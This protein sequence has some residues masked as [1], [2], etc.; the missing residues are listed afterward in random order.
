MLGLKGRTAPG[1][2]DPPGPESIVKKLVEVWFGRSASQGSNSDFD[3]VGPALGRRREQPSLR[4]EEVEVEP[5]ERG[6]RQV[7]EGDDH[8]AGLRVEL[9]RSGQLD[10]GAEAVA[11]DEE[12]VLVAG[13][14]FAEVDRPG[15]L[16]RAAPSCRS[17][18]CR[19]SRSPGTGRRA[20]RAEVGLRVAAGGL[21]VGG[22]GVDR[23]ALGEGDDRPPQ[24]RWRGDFFA[25]GLRH[26]QID[27]Q[28]GGRVGLRASSAAPSGSD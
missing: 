2:G 21:A 15:Q 22:V 13:Q 17:R 3:L 7:I 25:Q 14:R 23:E 26:P 27:V 28:A 10:V 11:G 8:A 12:P 1:H 24:L 16:G 18:S 19:P 6:L 5:L 4:A 9:D 20:G